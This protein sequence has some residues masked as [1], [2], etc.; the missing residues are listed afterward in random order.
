MT[1]YEYGDAPFRLTDPHSCL[2]EP[3]RPSGFEGDIYVFDEESALAQMTSM[4]W[5]VIGVG[6]ACTVE[7]G[8]V[9]G[10]PVYAWEDLVLNDGSVWHIMHED[11]CHVELEGYDD[12]D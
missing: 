1:E 4:L 5:R 12:D 8:K 2:I 7:A 10:G 9:Y 3:I 11:N 6:S